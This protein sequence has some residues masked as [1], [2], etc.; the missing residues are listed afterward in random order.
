MQT[1]DREKKLQDKKFA[2]SKDLALKEEAK[3]AEDAKAAELK[4]QNEQFWDSL[5]N[6]G[7]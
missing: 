2:Y 3:K 7:V 4:K 5:G 1:D 6:A